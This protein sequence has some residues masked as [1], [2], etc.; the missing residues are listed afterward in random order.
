MISTHL[1][2]IGREQFCARFHSDSLRDIAY[3]PIRHQVATAGE[4]E[5]KLI[6]MRDWQEVA[7]EEVIDAKGHAS[8]PLDKLAWTAD[9]AYVSVSSRN[10]ALYVYAVDTD[11]SSGD[12]SSRAARMRQRHLDGQSIARKMIFNPLSASGTIAAIGVVVAATTLAVS[13]AVGIHALDMWK[14]AADAWSI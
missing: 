12:A 8:G 5:I 1:D 7:C 14:I 3:C 4:S 10:G 6:D 13:H 9:G 11:I 2:E